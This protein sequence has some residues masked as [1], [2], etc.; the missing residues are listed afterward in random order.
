MIIYIKNLFWTLCVNPQRSQRVFYIVT[1]DI[2]AKSN[3]ENIINPI[4]FPCPV[5]NAKVSADTKKLTE[6]I[7]NIIAD[8]ISPPRFP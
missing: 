7:A 2:I 6:R 1:V 4:S 8:K 5:N 3:P